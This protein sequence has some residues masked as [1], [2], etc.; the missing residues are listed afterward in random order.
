M[1]TVLPRHI[2]NLESLKLPEALVTAIRRLYQLLYDLRD[3]VLEIEA[4]LDAIAPVHG[5][6]ANLSTSADTAYFTP[7]P[8]AGTIIRWSIVCPTGATATVKWWKVPL[9]TAAPTAGDSINTSGVSLATGDVIRSTLL[10]D[11]TTTTINEGDLLAV[12]MTAGTDPIVVSLEY[13]E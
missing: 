13:Q 2:P 3:K 7:A 1:A 4:E 12:K 10:T 9:G 5:F 8:F 6:G 11:F